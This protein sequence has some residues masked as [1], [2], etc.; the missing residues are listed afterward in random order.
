MLAA[1][2]APAAIIDIGSGAVAPDVFPSSN[3]SGVT[4]LAD[5]GVQTVSF[6]GGM[7]TGEY[8]EFVAS[9]PM[10]TFCPGCLDFGVILSVNANSASL[11][12]FRFGRWGGASTDV[13]YSPGLHPNGTVI[14][15]TVFR[16]GGN[17]IGFNFSSFASGVSDFLIVETNTTSF[18][19]GGF[20]L[21]N[22]SNN[23]DLG[24]PFAIGNAFVP[25]PEPATGALIAFGTL[26]LV[27]F[28]RDLIRKSS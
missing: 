26:A 6:D 5:T 16:G 22:D 25:I 1:V 2:P 23:T 7:F 19:N 21:F 18:G 13:G 28:R 10:N 20:F 14:P 12:T 17:Y 3:F 8:E 4:V 9:D 27:G 15:D 11:A 24:S